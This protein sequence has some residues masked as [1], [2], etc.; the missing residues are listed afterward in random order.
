MPGL[1]SSAKCNR[2]K[3]VVGNDLSIDGITSFVEVNMEERNSQG[4]L[5]PLHFAST[6]ALDFSTNV[7]AR[8]QVP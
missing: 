7:T 5:G 2:H 1:N 8:G 3:P 6:N 4:V